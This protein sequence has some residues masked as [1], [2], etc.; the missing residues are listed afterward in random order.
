MA[1]TVIVFFL[2][3]GGKATESDNLRSGQA[4]HTG[5][6]IV[7]GNSV[8]SGSGSGSYG[9]SDAG[10]TAAGDADGTSGGTTAGE[11]GEWYENS[12]N[13]A[14]D[15]ENLDEAVEVANSDINKAETSE[16]KKEEGMLSQA[17][18]AMGSAIYSGMKSI[19]GSDA[20]DEEV[21]KMAE[22]VETKLANETSRDFEE[23]A[24][25]IAER[26]R[27]S[28]SDVV[29]S[30]T[31][32][33]LDPNEIE[34]DVKSTEGEALNSVRTGI[35]SAAEQIKQRL[36]ER[37]AEVE[38]G[39][40]E[41]RLSQRLGRPVSLQIVDGNIQRMPEQGAA[42][43][44]NGYGAPQGYQPQQG[45]FQQGGFQPQ[46]AFQG[47]FQQPPYQGQYGYQPQ[48]GYQQ[49][50]PQQGYYQPPPPQQ[51]GYNPAGSYGGAAGAPG[52]TNGYQ[53][54]APGTA[55]G[56]AGYSS[57]SGGYGTTG[58]SGTGSTGPGTGGSTTFGAA[59]A[60]DDDNNA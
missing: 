42:M 34:S 41:Q 9:G 21:K 44:M 54:A 48:G 50:P 53:G 57:G 15:Q 30:E 36:R 24:D 58:S 2:S 59:A 22:E 35:D 20:T 52:N 13:R 7:G 33:G 26:A 8:S 55:T 18:S 29:E 25:E 51:G 32:Q 4:H 43:G 10:T 37:A 3:L 45:G 17:L 39:I 40:M 49:Q 12:E 23:R 27:N 60:K 47:G 19:M 1:I 38:K 56:A 6:E 31:E 46:G 11:G 14:A 28:I 16:V 5:T